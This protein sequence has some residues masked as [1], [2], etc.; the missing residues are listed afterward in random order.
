MSLDSVDVRHSGEGDGA[1][2]Q[3]RWTV[4]SRMFSTNLKALDGT[5]F[6]LSLVSLLEPTGFMT[7]SLPN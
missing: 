3:P 6:M 7:Q 1:L 2:G 4:I 5:L